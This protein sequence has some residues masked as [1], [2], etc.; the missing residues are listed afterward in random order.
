MGMG[1]SD[2][3]G[4]GGVTHVEVRLLLPLLASDCY[5]PFGGA[6][7]FR[8]W[9]ALKYADNILK[10]FAV[11]CSIVLNCGVSSLF[12]GVPLTLQACCQATASCRATVCRTRLCASRVRPLRP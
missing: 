12:L 4:W 1:W 6:R 5:V 2:P 3:W 9:Q 11:G 7:R 8:I 10:T